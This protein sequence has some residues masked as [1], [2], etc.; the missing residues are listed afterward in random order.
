MLH[1]RNF[2]KQYNQHLI[3]KFEELQLSS[4]VYWFKGENGS[5][6]STL[7]KSLAGLLPFEGDATLN[8]IDLKKQPIEYRKYVN[9]SEAEPTFPGF[10]TAKDLIRFV[11]KA[12]DSNKQQQE[13]YTALFGV[14]AYFEQTCETFSSGMLKKLSLSLAFLGEPHVIILDEPLITLD[15]NARKILLNHVKAL[16]AEKIFLLS[17]HQLLDDMEIPVNGIFKIQNQSLLVD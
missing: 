3:L 5:G 13:L 11:G 8:N 17:S 14:D 9:Y 12:K 10:V 6:K 7:F 4:G 15:E 1:I 16:S 2:K